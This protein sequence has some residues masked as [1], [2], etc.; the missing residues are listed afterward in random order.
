MAETLVA[1]WNAGN[2]D[3]TQPIQDSDTWDNRTPAEKYAELKLA[4]ETA[5]AEFTASFHGSTATPKWIFVGA[6]YALG[7]TRATAADFQA[8]MLQIR[9]LS[10]ENNNP[11]LVPGTGMMAHPNAEKTLAYNYSG[12]FHAGQKMAELGK[13]G[14]VSEP[15][16]D[17][18]TFQAGTGKATFDI[19]GTTFGIQICQ[20]ATGTVPFPR[21]V[22]VQIVM[23]R[24]VGLRTTS[25]GPGIQEQASKY[26]I[27][28]DTYK[29]DVK[30]CGQA[31]TVN[32][33]KVKPYGGE[34]LANSS[35]GYYKIDI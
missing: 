32:D 7:N 22:D 6:E 25:G 5:A 27:V 20:D 12:A 29:Q 35:I 16:G 18:Y 8:M 34:N 2:P 31:R 15:V 1:I 26:I 19:S 23:G 30:F 17:D 3:H 14:D 21:N 33:I 24:G 9:G 28:A 4:V 11:L 13:K 10:G